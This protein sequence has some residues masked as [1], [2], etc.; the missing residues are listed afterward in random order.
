MTARRTFV[1]GDLH[2]CVE[3]LDRLLDTCAPTSTDTVVFLGDYIDRG[4]SPRGVIDRL[5]RLRGE[6]PDCV[7]LK[8]NHEDM[9][10]AFLGYPGRYGEAFV[11]NGGAATL[12]SYGLPE[13]PA[14]V[15]ATALPPGH[16]E[17]LLGLRLQYPCGRF[18]CVHAGLNPARPLHDQQDE[19]LLW[20]RE[21]FVLHP[22]SFPVTVV[23]GHSPHR[24]VR[25]D[26]PY[27]IGLDTGLVYWNKLSCLELTEKRL[28]Q[29]R[30][31]ERRV[32]ST[33][34]CG[35]FEQAA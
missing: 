28:F 14:A 4:P 10:L 8:G 31:G 33:S 35:S 12:R 18:L 13:D 32:H 3:E 29:I 17:F 1:I 6:G 2:G 22:H 24:E 7:F 9:F 30:R 25:L 26:L 11:S 15:E 16:L 23:F 5:L 20:I 34:L 19:D 21:E 27:K